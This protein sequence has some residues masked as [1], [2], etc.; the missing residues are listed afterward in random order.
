MSGAQPGQL[1]SG[2]GITGSVFSNGWPGFRSASVPAATA[3]S[4]GPVTITQSAFGAPS[5]GQTAPNVGVRGALISTVALFL[6]GL[7][8]WSLPK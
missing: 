6:L 8:W 2:I 1:G 7:F 3:A 4:E 5:G